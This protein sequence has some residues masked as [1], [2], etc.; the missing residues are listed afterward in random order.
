MLLSA[1]SL[2]SSGNFN[3]SNGFLTFP[4]VNTSQSQTISGKK[5]FSTLPESS[6]VPTTDNQLVNKKYVDDNAYVLP[7]AAQTT[8]GGVKMYVDENNILQ[9]TTN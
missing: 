3:I 9:I 2:N 4:L 1:F 8:L 7:A 6:V 5:T